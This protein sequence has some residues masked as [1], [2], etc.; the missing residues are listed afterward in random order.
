MELMVVTVSLRLGRQSQMR[1]NVRRWQHMEYFITIVLLLK[2][3]VITVNTVRRFSIRNKLLVAEALKMNLR[4]PKPDV[5]AVFNQLQHTDGVN[6]YFMDENRECAIYVDEVPVLIASP[7][8]DSKLVMTANLGVLR[9]S[10][11]SSSVYHYLLQLNFMLV[12]LGYVSLC[13]THDNECLLTA[14]YSIDN[15]QNLDVFGQ[16]FDEFSI[17][18]SELKQGV[19][20]KITR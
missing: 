17:I 10:M 1:L 9:E 14:I 7:E 2:Q 13:L 11:N 3:R 20:E 16:T 8:G 12:E 6:N 18:V 15:L 5:V 4:S 19:L